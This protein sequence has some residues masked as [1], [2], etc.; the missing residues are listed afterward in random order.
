[1][2]APEFRNASRSTRRG[3]PPPEGPRPARTIALIGMIAAVYAVVTIALAPLSYGPVQVRVSEALTLL[4][5][6]LGPW[7]AV[8][9]WIGC[10]LANA[11]GGFGLLDIVF[12]CGITLAAGL[13]SSRM[14]SLTLAALWPIVL[15]AFGVAGVLYYAARL[16]Y[17][18]SV[19]YVG[20]GQI[21]AVAALGMPLMTWLRTR[22]ILP[23][24]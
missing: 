10:M 20:A 4:P 14:P 16:P 8:G 11:Y 19:L 13:L 23:R 6:F 1:M 12:G 5:F 3:A 2:A 24:G 15:N 7:S 17:W 9:L 21:I 22:G 18:P